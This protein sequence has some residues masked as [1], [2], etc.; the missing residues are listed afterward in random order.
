M[1]HESWRVLLHNTIILMIKT[2]TNSDH[3]VHI[4]LFARHDYVARGI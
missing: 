2:S 4:T 1:I 3:D